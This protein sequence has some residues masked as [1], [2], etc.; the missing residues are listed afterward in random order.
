MFDLDVIRNAEEVVSG[1]KFLTEPKMK[2]VDEALHERSDY[3]KKE[4][5][6]ILLRELMRLIGR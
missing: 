1:W 5:P 4:L 3:V 6:R 2:G